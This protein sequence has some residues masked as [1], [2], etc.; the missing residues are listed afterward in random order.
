MKKIIFLLILN[1]FFVFAQAPTIEWDK[2]IGGAGL[3][4]CV[5][6]IQTS[7][8]GYVAIGHSD[9]DI[10]FD[11]TH[12]A[13]N[14]DYWIIKIN[15][16]GNII[17]QKNYGGIEEDF[18]VR[19]LET[20]DSGFLVTGTSD[21]PISGDNTCGPITISFPPEQYTWLL[22]LD[23]LGEISWQKA[24]NAVAISQLLQTTNNQYIIAGTKWTNPPGWGT[25][26]YY[27]SKLDI[28][29]NT[30]WE[31]TVLADNTDYFGNIILAN[32]GGY[33]VGGASRSS[34]N[35]DKTEGPIGPPD[36]YGI[37]STDIWIL[38]IS[39]N[40]Q[41]VWQNTI[42]G[43]GY[44][45]VTC[46]KSNGNNS[47]TLVGGTTSPVSGDKTL[48]MIDTN[49]FWVIDIDNMGNVI[50]QSSF[51]FGANYNQLTNIIQY[52]DKD[53]DG[54][55][56]IFGFKNW[57]TTNSQIYLKKVNPL[58]NLLWEKVI[59]GNS[60]DRIDSVAKTS[61]GGY[62]LGCSSDSSI[63]GDKT[64]SARDFSEDYWIIKLSPDNL[65]SISLQKNVYQVF[66]NPTS[67]NIN[68][69]FGQVLEKATLTLANVLGQVVANKTVNNLEYTTF[70]IN[71][72]PDGIYFLE[73]VS[74]QNARQ[75]MK[76]I[77][78]N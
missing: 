19:I 67:G 69:K 50:G 36:V 52:I 23:S 53:E 59:D 25:E 33:I 12:N 37:Y 46:I 45:G 48:P 40:G 71:D 43:D 8:G 70:E 77:K 76:I 72:E 20:K 57:Q 32:D 9:S 60:R 18:P 21:S 61:D 62:I 16:L 41:I 54:N 3:D 75:V 68:I 55:F 10:S 15:A 11:K 51:G 5:Q 26:D 7:D 1:P 28:L 78:Q 31:K 49:D 63:S 73:I 13:L 27:L 56:M 22:K 65:S 58:G 42:G 44:E 64:E 24:V 39:E 2:T 66:P 35:L 6:I 4:N 74:H 34:A 47:Y 17:W 30:I 29:G 14:A 38:K